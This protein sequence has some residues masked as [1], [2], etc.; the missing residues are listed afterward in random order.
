MCCSFLC[1]EKSIELTHMPCWGRRI[2]FTL[3]KTVEER[4]A[5]LQAFIDCRA[6]RCSYRTVDV[7]SRCIP[8]LFSSLQPFPT[9]DLCKIKSLLLICCSLRLF[10]L[11]GI[12][13]ELS[14]SYE[15]AGLLR[16]ITWF[17]KALRRMRDF[18]CLGFGM[19]SPVQDINVNGDDARI[20]ARNGV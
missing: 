18:W 13:K 2:S 11:I 8:R 16:S 17:Q 4:F 7:Q 12:Y 19:Q 5:W 20:C 3:Y 6:K 10:A 14:C 1:L 15:L 9:R